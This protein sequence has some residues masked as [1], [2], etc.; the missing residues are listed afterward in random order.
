[1]LY[2]SLY[3]K[4]HQQHYYELLNGIRQTGE[5]EAWLDFFG[6]AVIITANQAMDTA[7]KILS[8]ASTDREKIASLGRASASTLKIYEALL[9]HPIGTAKSLVEKTGITPAT[10]NKSLGHLKSL[11]IVSE[12]TKKKRNRI[13]CCHQYVE[14]M[15]QDI[16]LFI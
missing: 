2:L 3:F 6:D 9:K 13:F 12:L 14:I 15:N 11:G 1:M 16:D 10:V 5:W 8:L 7:Q 4:T